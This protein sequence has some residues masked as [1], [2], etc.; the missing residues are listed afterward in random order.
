MLDSAARLER[1]ERPKSKVPGAPVPLTA[2]P[3]A[4]MRDRRVPADPPDAGQYAARA[5]AAEAMAVLT[6][7]G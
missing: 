4:S 7:A 6:T 5:A 2:A 3:I 1:L